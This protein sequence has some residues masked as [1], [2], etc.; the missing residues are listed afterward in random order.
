[1]EHAAGCTLDVLALDGVFLHRPRRQEAVMLPPG[2]RV[3]LGVRCFNVAVPLPVQLVTTSAKGFH[4]GGLFP[5]YH[6]VLGL[7]I[8]GEEG[9]DEHHAADLILPGT[10]PFY[11]DLR[12]RR[13]SAVYG[14]VFGD[15]K[16]THSVNGRAYSG[17]VS[18]SMVVGGV[19]EWRLRGGE[20]PGLLK[21]HPYHQHSTHFQIVAVEAA[22]SA[23]LPAPEIAA[24]AVVGD[25][26]DTVPLYY[27]IGYT[28]RF[29]PAFPGRMMV[30][31][32]ILKHEDEGMMM[33]ADM[34]PPHAD[35]GRNAGAR[36]LKTQT[37]T[38]THRHTHARARARTHTDTHKHTH[39]CRT[40]LH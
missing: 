1:M 21:M 4:L 10:P 34:L 2:G 20:P 32:H 11:P 24:L 38:R 27:G 31:C 18:Y 16:G 12:S 3:E 33:L 40:E 29:R 9:R 37:H 6:V 8:Y 14:V 35:A 26:R 13:A 30:H 15:A 22:E 28:V 25:Y 7:D 5:P 36:E 23:E 17:N 19:Q 39:T